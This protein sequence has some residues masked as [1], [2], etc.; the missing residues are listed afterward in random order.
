MLTSDP[1]KR[2]KMEDLLRHPWLL[3]ENEEPVF[4]QQA[5]ANLLPLVPQASVINYMTKMFDFKESEVLNALGERKVN[6][7]AATYYPT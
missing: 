7:I 4:R 6:S 3:G 1:R 2:I 5:V